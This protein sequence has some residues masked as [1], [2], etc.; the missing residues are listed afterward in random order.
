M[1]SIDKD[2]FKRFLKKFP[3]QIKESENLFT[4]AKVKIV[5][6]NFDNII[7]FGMGGSAIAGDI[8]RST[9]FDEIKLPFVVVRGYQ[10]PNFCSNRSLV[11]VSSYSGNTEET[12]AAAQ[13]AHKKGGH[14]VAITTGGKIEELAQKHSWKLIKIPAGLPPRQAFGYSFFPL[15]YLLNPV[16]KKKVDEKEV[17]DVLRLIR[18]MI[19]RNDEKTAEGK[20]LSKDMAIEIHHR[21]PI[22]YTTA[23]YL[24][25]VAI[26]WKN[27][28]QENSKSMAFHNVIPEM[29]HNE[30]VG[31][32]MEHRCLKNFIVIFLETQDSQPRIRARIEL[33]KKLIQK[34]GA[35]VVSLYAEGD[36]RLQH[37]LSLV[38]KGDWVSYYLALLYEKNP[39]D[40]VN[41]DL[42]KSELE[43][44]H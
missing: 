33:T 40:I 26:R 28:F 6:K 11:V 2:D 16:L 13:Q 9:F 18:L 34:R 4:A 42:L 37:V 39:M 29:N 10:C 36:S 14:I 41:I 32:E 7:Y 20:I 25:S 27:Q 19:K 35:E 43:K 30:I 21:V 5:A 15:I 8:Y 3:D 44:Q 1:Y 24:E 12:I 31:W 22:I 17:K 38:C 23:P